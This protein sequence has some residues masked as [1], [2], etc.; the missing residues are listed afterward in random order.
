[1]RLEK[2]PFTRANEF[3][4]KHE[5]IQGFSTFFIIF[6]LFSKKS[7]DTVEA[8][9]WQWYQNHEDTLFQFEKDQERVFE[10]LAVELHK[11]RPDLTFE[12]G[13]VKNG[14][15][16]FVISADGI[17]AA[18]PAVEFVFASAPKLK[19]WTFIKFRPRRSPMNL[20]YGG[21]QVSRR[22]ILHT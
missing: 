15:R 2:K 20:D 9:F 22:R 14:R 16:D 5:Y 6:S 7:V 12:F 13:P 11:I 4:P 10:I 17:K 18:F 21:V 8:R 1:M 19:R 3:R